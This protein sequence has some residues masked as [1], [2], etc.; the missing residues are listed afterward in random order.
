VTTRNFARDVGIQ[1]GFMGERSPHFGNS[2]GMSFPNTISVGGR[3]T[4]TVATS[5][6]GGNTGEYA[7]NLPATAPTTGVGVAVGNVLGSF[8]LDVALSALEK[9]GRGRILSTPKITT[10]DNQLAEIKQG[11]QFPILVEMNNTI[12]LVYKDAT[13]SLKVTPQ[14]TEANTVILNLILENNSAD[15]SRMV[16]GAPSIQIQEAKTVVLVNDGETAVV[17]GVYKSQEDSTTSRTP[18]LGKIPLLG[19]LFQEKVATQENQELL[20]FITPHISKS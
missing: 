18:F 10:Q 19:F 4:N 7:V 9:Q 6:V 1:W 2:T 16:Q 15:F 5:M 8:N 12:T 20:L 11:L 14:I 3:G 17:G 13:L